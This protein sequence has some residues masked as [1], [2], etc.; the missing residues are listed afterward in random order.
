M[1]DYKKLCLELFGTDNEAELRKIAGR[2][3]SGRKKA[4]S[5]NDID[6]IIKMQQQGRTTKELPSILV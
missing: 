3:A 6:T 5:N 1:T 2:L 4:L